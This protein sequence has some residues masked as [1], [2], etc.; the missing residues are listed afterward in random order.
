MRDGCL[1]GIGKGNSD[2]NYS[3]PHGAGR[4]LSRKEAKEKINL[5]DYENAM[6]QIFTTS[7]N[8][9]TLDESPF[10]YKS[11]EEILSHIG[12]TVEV[13]SI[14]K[15]VYNFKASETSMFSKDEKKD[16]EGMMNNGGKIL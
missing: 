6:S 1:L 15:P 8:A 14:I 7:V 12:D 2:W 13:T 4:I 10:A 9:S 5:E 11:L 3:A 16:E